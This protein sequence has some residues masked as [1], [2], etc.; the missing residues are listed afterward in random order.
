MNEADGEN[1]DLDKYGEKKLLICPFRRQDLRKFIEC[2]LL[3]VI[4]KN[5]E[6]KIWEETPISFGK[7]E[8]T[9]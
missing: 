3:E 5:K 7:K 4:Y 6:H 9:K 8:E 2:I 1:N